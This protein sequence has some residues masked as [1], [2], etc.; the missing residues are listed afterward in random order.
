A[1]G[2]HPA[3]LAASARTGQRSFRAGLSRPILVEDHQHLAAHVGVTLHHM[4]VSAEG[5]DFVLVAYFERRGLNSHRLVAVGREALQRIGRPLLRH[6][7]RAHKH[8]HGDGSSHD[9]AR[10]DQP[11]L[12]CAPALTVGWSL[13]GVITTVT[14]PSKRI[15]LPDSW[16]SSRFAL[17]VPCCM[18]TS[19]G[20]SETISLVRTLTA[21]SL[22]RAW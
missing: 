15:T 2:F 8:K 3:D 6:C 13:C 11:R 16:T 12:H 9:A 14:P 22:R 4:D 7:A 17:M 19:T 21:A 1:L 18:V 10:V 20:F 5:R